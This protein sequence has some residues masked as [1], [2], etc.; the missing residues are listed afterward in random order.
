VVL[1]RFVSPG[2]LDRVKFPGAMTAQSVAQ[3]RER[4]ELNACWGRGTIS[5]GGARRHLFRQSV[6]GAT[7][8]QSLGVGCRNPDGHCPVSGGGARDQVVVQGA[9]S[10]E[11][12]IDGRRVQGGKAA[13]T[14]QTKLATTNQS[15]GAGAA[16]ADWRLRDGPGAS[17]SANYQRE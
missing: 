7:Q 5:G 2:V 8:A 4:W 14:R 6:T 11:S 17:L 3:L 16:Q 13:E 10:Q 12:Q 15:C 9:T 1:V